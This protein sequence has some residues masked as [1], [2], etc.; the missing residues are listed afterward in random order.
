[1]DKKY[2]VFISS[3]FTDLKEARYQVLNTILSMYHIPAGME[4]F[5]ATDSKQWELIKSE[6]LSSDYY[7]LIL[8]HRYGS[9]TE[10]GISYTEKEFDFALENKIPILAFIKDRDTPTRPS[11]RENDHILILKLDKFYNKVIQNRLCEF[12]ITEEE[13]AKKVSVCLNKEFKN[14]TR[15]GWIRDYETT[16]NVKDYIKIYLDSKLKAGIKS[17]TVKNYTPELEILGKFFDTTPINIITSQK[18]ME[19]LEYRQEAFNVNA[20]STLET[21]RSV[22][23]TFFQWLKDENLIKNNPVDKIPTY[24]NNKTHAIPIESKNIDKLRL[25]CETL[26]ESAILETFLST[27]CKLDEI[28]N[29][30]IRNFDPNNKTIHIEKTNM[31]PRLVP[32]NEITFI[33]LTKYLSSRADSESYLFVTERKPYRQLTRRAI[34]FDINKIASRVS[35]EKTVNTKA[36]RRT[37]AQKLVEQ[38]CPLNIIQSLLGHSNISNTKET[39]FTIKTSNLEA[40]RKF[41]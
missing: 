1:M 27:G 14:S 19:Y 35:L 2:Q 8:G 9:L 26:R 41:L 18:I 31:N 33:A 15:P 10:E 36:L 38:E 22:I 13:L 3:T 28:I 6:I 5:S 20:K 23:K 16:K 7:I 17:I 24:K 11:E 12:W 29:L 37:F 39:Y 40:V 30:S 4:L 25:S 32:I 21:I 34:Q